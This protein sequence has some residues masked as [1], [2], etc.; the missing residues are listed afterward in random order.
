MQWLPYRSGGT[1]ALLTVLGILPRQLRITLPTRDP[2]EQDRSRQ[3]KLP[4]LLP[5]PEVTTCSTPGRRGLR[6]RQG[7]KEAVDDHVLEQN[8]PQGVHPVCRSTDEDQNRQAKLLLRQDLGSRLH[9]SHKGYRS[10]GVADRLGGEGE[11]RSISWTRIRVCKD[12]VHWEVRPLA[13]PPP[14]MTFCASQN[15]I[16]TWVRLAGKASEVQGTWTDVH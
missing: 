15:S 2:P 4:L 7:E 14:N 12:I 5:S 9:Q 3:V 13:P 11:G 10:E 1:R 16:S 8:R 6:T